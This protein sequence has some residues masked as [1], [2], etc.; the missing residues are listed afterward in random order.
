MV[1]DK[2]LQGCSNFQKRILFGDPAQ[3][4]LG[5]IDAEL[6]LWILSKYHSFTFSKS[7]WAFWISFR[8]FEK[9]NFAV[10]LNQASW[11]NHPLVPLKLTFWFY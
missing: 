5:T 3:E 6:N 4:I 10:F 11:Q 2:Q 1:C 8:N 7:I 9:G